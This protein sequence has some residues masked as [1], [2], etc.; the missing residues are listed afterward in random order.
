MSDT[1]ELTPKQRA[2]LWARW[3]TGNEEVV[4]TDTETCGIGPHAPIVD[5]AIVDQAG[6]VLL[7]SLVNP[8]I[9]IPPEASA[10]HGIH[11]A[12]VAMAPA[13]DQL[14]EK[15]IKLLGGRVVCVYNAGFDGI[16]INNAIIRAGRAPIATRWE[17][18]MLAYGDWD[19]TP[20]TRGPGMKWHK[21]S[22]A[23][24]SFGIEPGNHRALADTEA[25][26]LLVAAMATG[27]ERNG[28]V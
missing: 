6:K 26:R 7:N 4:Y 28:T 8:G 22:A 16:V 5:I 11:D 15:V 24:A 25:A 9:P 1:N 3:I 23:C 19:G 13:F 20:S 18:A 27:E 14:A 2:I 17:C 12:D 21:L 10:V